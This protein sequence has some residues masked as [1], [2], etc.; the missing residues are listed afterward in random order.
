MCR[1]GAGL[2]AAVPP[3]PAPLQP[4]E[5]HQTVWWAQ[6]E[7]AELRRLVGLHGAGDWKLIK[8]QGH[9]VFKGVRSAVDLKD[10]W[11]LMRPGGRKGRVRGAAGRD[12]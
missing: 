2:T 1:P 7:E 12:R 5:A 6:E 10:K 11:R 3:D 9:A 4:L 8:A